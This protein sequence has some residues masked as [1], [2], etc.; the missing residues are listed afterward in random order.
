M[1]GDPREAS[2]A[3]GPVLDR[4][5]YDRIQSYIRAAIEE[6]GR[7]LGGGLGHP[8][9]LDHGNYVKPTLMTATNDQTIAREEIF[10]PVLA[11]I[12]SRDED[13]AAAIAN[14]TPYGL[15]AYVATSD[16]ARGERLVQRLQ[17]GRIMIN[18]VVDSRQAPFGGFKQSVLGREFD[19][20]G[21]NAY[22]EDQAIFIS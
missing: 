7:V 1:V 22:V 4:Q 2:T 21:I 18:K 13:E 17:A 14:D 10:G 11:V 8:D 12:T 15:H 16:P 3:I 19:T 5:Q 9:G 6:G 20:W